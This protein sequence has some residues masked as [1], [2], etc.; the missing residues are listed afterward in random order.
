MSPVIHNTT[1]LLWKTALP[2]QPMQVC[3]ILFR[4]GIV[5]SGPERIL[6]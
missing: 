4:T 6:P 2:N 3:R 5:V 1:G